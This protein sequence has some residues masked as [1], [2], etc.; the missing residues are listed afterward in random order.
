MKHYLAKKMRTFRGGD[1][2][3]SEFLPQ[4]VYELKVHIARDD[5]TGRWYVATSD[6]PG[7]RLEADNPMDLIARVQDAAPDLLELNSEEVLAAC[8]ARNP[9]PKK[10]AAQTVKRATSIL[11][12]FDS[13]MQLAHA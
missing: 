9:A 11:P 1:N 3:R 4:E 13:P 12:I 10:K 2:E 8:R 5:E 6:I 7:L